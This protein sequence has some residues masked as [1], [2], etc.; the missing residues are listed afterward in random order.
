[1]SATPSNPL[2]DQIS[3]RMEELER[4]E[5]EID[6]A[7]D[8]VENNPDTPAHERYKILFKTQHQLGNIQ[9]EIFEIEREMNKWMD[10]NR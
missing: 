9:R 2:F 1:M 4:T 10:N 7:L 5:Q 3:K 6:Q 8:F